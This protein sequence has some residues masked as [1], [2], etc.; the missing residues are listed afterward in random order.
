MANF[1]GGFKF[2]SDFMYIIDGVVCNADASTVD[3]SK[4]VSACGQLWDGEFFAVTNI[5]GS[6][7]ITLRGSVGEEFDKPIMMR[8]PCGIGLDGR[9]FGIVRRNNRLGLF[10]GFL[11]TVNVLPEDATITVTDVNGN[12]VDPIGT[13]QY[14]LSDF[15]DTYT[16]TCVKAGFTTE[17]KQIKNTGKQTVDIVMKASV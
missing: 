2:Q 9:F 4:A 6:K 14:M 10:P 8:G 12:E 13:N 17:T 3:K 5:G 15:G 1:C 11:L 7:C 16:V